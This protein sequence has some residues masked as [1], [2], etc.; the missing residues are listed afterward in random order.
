[1]PDNRAR[2]CRRRSPAGNAP[3]DRARLGGVLRKR[4]AKK[5]MKGYLAL[6]D[7]DESG[8]WIARVPSIPG[9]HT[10]GRTLE[11]ARRRIREAL[12]LWI[13]HPERA[14]LDFDVRLPGRVIAA[15]RPVETARARADKARF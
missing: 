8:A 11:A 10:Y 2:S 15:V 13:D 5:A 7:R 14:R 4:M 12:G 9:C 1:M 3:R 6:V